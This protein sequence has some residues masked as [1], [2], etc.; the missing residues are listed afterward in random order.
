MFYDPIAQRVIDYVDGEQDLSRRVIRAI[1]NPADRFREDKLRMLRAIRFTAAYQFTLD[2][3]TLSAVQKYAADLQLVSAE[4]I[5]AE[6]RRMLCHANRASAVDLLMQSDLLPEIIPE[7]GE[8]LSTELNSNRE[9][10]SVRESLRLLPAT[11]VDG[12]RWNETEQFISAMA[13]LLFPIRTKAIEVCH[14]LKLSKEETTG[15]EW[16]ISNV[17][18]V[19]ESAV[20]PWPQIQRVLIQPL[21]A[22]LVVFASSIAQA[23]GGDDRG[24][25]FCQESLLLSSDELNPAPFIGGDD[26]VALGLR[27]GR[28]FK[29]ILDS[30]RN[31]QLMKKITTKDE[32]LAEALRVAEQI[33]F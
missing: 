2:P 5:A 15:I 18:T 29:L 14:R 25:K 23:T 1:G 21:A 7:F 9:W 28:G 8:V 16:L 6:L 4:R 24:W 20:R 33:E 26:L 13:C 32:A 11:S 30:V 12:E 10:Q 19:D 27:P 31:A 17:S 22:Q 3:E